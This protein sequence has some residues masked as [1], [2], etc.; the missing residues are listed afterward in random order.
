MPI[1]CDNVIGQRTSSVNGNLAAL[2][3]F[4]ANGSSVF[5]HYTFMTLHHFGAYDV[6]VLNCLIALFR[7]VK[8][9]LDLE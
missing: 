6:P 4:V 9:K 7:T 1:S 2:A 5:N 8:V 3:G